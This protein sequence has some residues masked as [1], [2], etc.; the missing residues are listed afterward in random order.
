MNLC[1]EVRQI[2]LR[3]HMLHFAKLLIPARSHTGGD[4]RVDDGS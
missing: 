3:S 4:A 1:E 2:V